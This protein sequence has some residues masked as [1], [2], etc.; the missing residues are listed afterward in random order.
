MNRRSIAWVIF[1]GVLA[2]A[3]AGGIAGVGTRAVQYGI[4]AFWLVLTACFVWVYVRT[5]ASADRQRLID[6]RGIN[7]LPRS[8]RRW[9]APIIRVPE[10]GRQGLADR[11]VR[12]SLVA[13]SLCRPVVQAVSCR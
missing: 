6:T 3:G 4:W 8:S 12:N 1:L 7:L 13:V 9:A 5:D 11:L 2:L 10:T